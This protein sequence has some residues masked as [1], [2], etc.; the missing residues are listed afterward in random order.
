MK[1]LIINAAAEASAPQVMN[2]ETTGPRP[3]LEVRLHDLEGQKK[4][5][6]AALEAT[7]KD[8]LLKAADLRI[9]ARDTRRRAHDLY[10]RALK[11]YAGG[12]GQ[13]K[14]LLLQAK[15]RYSYA[16]LTDEKANSL[17]HLAQVYGMVINYMSDRTG[18]TDM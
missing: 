15:L 7:R 4:E 12:E 14:V 1:Y 3:D 9:Q 16:R 10:K 2:S 11:A 6:L 17:S 18:G 8:T 13:A 5:G